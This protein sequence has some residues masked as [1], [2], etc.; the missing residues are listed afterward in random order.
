M[1]VR[2]GGEF[3]GRSKV[4]QLDLLGGRIVENVLV[5]QVS[6]IDILQGEII[7]HVDQLSDDVSTVPGGKSSVFVDVVEEIVISRVVLHDDIPGK[8]FIFSVDLL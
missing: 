8:S 3:P 5:L 6:M 4:Y 1:G 7:D 2:F